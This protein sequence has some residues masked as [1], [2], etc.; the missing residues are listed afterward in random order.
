MSLSLAVFFILTIP[1]DIVILL[2]DRM[3]FVDWVSGKF[4]KD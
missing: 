2:P 1:L 4:F 3:V